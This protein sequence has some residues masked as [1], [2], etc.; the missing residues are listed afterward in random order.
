MTTE[1]TRQLVAET[2]YAMCLLCEMG[3]VEATARIE[4]TRSAS[5]RLDRPL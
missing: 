1:T 2:G 4:D 3:G 5:D